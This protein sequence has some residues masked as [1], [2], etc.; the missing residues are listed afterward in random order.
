MNERNVKKEVG[1][2]TPNNVLM[3]RLASIG[4]ILYA[5][6]DAL[7][8]D[9][10]KYILNGIIKIFFEY[11]GMFIKNDVNVNINYFI[12]ELKLTCPQDSPFQRNFP[13]DILSVGRTIDEI[14]NVIT[15]INSILKWN[16][17]SE[18]RKIE[19]TEMIDLYNICFNFLTHG[20]PT[21]I[22][23]VKQYVS[24]IESGT[25]EFKSSLRW[26]YQNEKVDKQI[27][28]T[29]AKAICGFANAEGGTLI[30]GVDDSGNILGLEPDLA[31]FK[32]RN[33]REAMDTFE[34]HFDQ[35]VANT[36]QGF[37]AITLVD[38]KFIC[39]DDQ[40]VFLTKTKKSDK[41]LFAVDGDKVNFYVRIGNATR[42]FNVRESIEYCS[43]HF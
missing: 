4:G 2:P 22:V 5:K 39:I 30:I 28:K 29:S 23:E 25:L 24:E 20:E 40:Y 32:K 6:Q 9:D 21:E 14:Q 26:N 19:S 27:S 41:P 12:N 34:R 15:R 37:N 17:S 3:R 35:I 43:I 38:R 18:A 33:L 1:V 36:L 16:I 13:K 7:S 31:S 42:L 11:Y 8:T 10:I